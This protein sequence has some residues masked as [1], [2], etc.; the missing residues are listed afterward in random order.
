MIPIRKLSLFAYSNRQLL[1]L[2]NLQY[3]VNGNE[4]KHWI[5]TVLSFQR[6]SH[7]KWGGVLQI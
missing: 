5:L 6:I 1:D 7:D 4:N 2:S 3:D